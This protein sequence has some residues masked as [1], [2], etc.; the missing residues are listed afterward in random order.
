M[1]MLRIKTLVPDRR[2]LVNII[3]PEELCTYFGKMAH[4][5]IRVL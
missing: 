5:K 1:L 4:E 3:P 2:V